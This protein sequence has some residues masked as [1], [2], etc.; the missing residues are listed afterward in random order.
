M[1]RGSVQFSLIR[2]A[3][4]TV[5]GHCADGGAPLSDR[6][7]A[8]GRMDRWLDFKFSLRLL[9]EAATAGGT[10]E[11]ERRGRSKT[12]PRCCYDVSI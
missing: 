7:V 4:G 1:I 11:G 5:A 12:R 10:G 6:G 9:V 8:F 3:G 2:A